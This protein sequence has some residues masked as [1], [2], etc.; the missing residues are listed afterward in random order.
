MGWKVK[1]KAPK[2]KTPKFV[3]NIVGDTKKIGQGLTDFY[4]GG[5][6][7]DAGKQLGAMTNIASTIGE[8]TGLTSRAK[9]G[10]EGIVDMT[11]TE[12]PSTA[13]VTEDQNDILRK[14]LGAKFASRALFGGPGGGSAVKSSSSSLLG[15]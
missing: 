12:M 9:A 8:M 6:T 1:I 3:S 4:A 7:L 10:G 2:I 14:K 11:G 13:A 5:V 15:F